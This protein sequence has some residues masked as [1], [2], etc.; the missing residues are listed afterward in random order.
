MNHADPPKRKAIAAIMAMIPASG[1]DMPSDFEATGTKVGD[2][3]ACAMWNV[4][5]G[6]CVVLLGNV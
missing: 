2:D 6:V 3:V 1:S 5:L 4:E